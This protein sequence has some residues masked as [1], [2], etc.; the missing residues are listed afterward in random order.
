MK[1]S[2]LF[3]CGAER[4]ILASLTMVLEET[5]VV[6]V[7]NYSLILRALRISAISQGEMQF[8]SMAPVRCTPL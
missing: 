5:Q 1:H 8:N 4:L 7:S 2:N 6:G 3:S